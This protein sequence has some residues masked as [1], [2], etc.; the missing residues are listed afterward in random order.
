MR[1]KRQEWKEI[2]NGLTIKNNPVSVGYMKNKIWLVDVLSI[3][4]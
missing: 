4:V 3:C 1:L 2:T